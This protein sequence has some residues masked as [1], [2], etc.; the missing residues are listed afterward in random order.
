MDT[1]SR[2]MLA[3]SDK[4]LYIPSPPSYKTTNVL[5]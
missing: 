3:Y 1:E 2:S 5:W 4:Y